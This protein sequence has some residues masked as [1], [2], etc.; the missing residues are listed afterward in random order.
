MFGTQAPASQWVVDEQ[1]CPQ[2]PQFRPSMRT[3]VQLPILELG[4]QLGSPD[5][6]T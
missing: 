1:A 4:Q 2:A 5:G 6:Q 3:L